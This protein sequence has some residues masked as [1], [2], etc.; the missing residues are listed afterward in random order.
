MQVISAV[1]TLLLSFCFSSMCFVPSINN[2]HLFK[3]MPFLTP[4]KF[5][6]QEMSRTD[7]MRW[8]SAKA[9]IWRSLVAMQQC[10]LHLNAWASTPTAPSIHS[11]HP[12]SSHARKK[13]SEHT[14][15][16]RTSWIAKEIKKLTRAYDHILKMSC[17]VMVDKLVAAYPNAKVI[18]TNPDV[19]K[20]S[21]SMLK[22][23]D[24][25]SGRKSWPTS[26]LSEPHLVLELC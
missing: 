10:T 15:R 21:L 4:Q 9:A 17:A 22:S 20:W 11:K 6:A 5:P 26:H 7:T 23:I 1:Y 3:D 18:L 12:R 16:Q 25:V 8:F 2:Q 24:V 14:S 13:P 19:D